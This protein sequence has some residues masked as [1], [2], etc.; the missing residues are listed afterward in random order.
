MLIP[1]KAI[2]EK[3]TEFGIKVTG[4][5]H[6][7]AHECEEGSFYT[8]DLQVPEENLLWVEAIQAKVDEAK[9]K[10]IKHIYQYLVSDQDDKM[11]SFHITNNVQSSSILQFGTHGTH[12]PHIKNISTMSLE[13]KTVD[14]IIR[15][16]RN[17]TTV[18]N[19]WNF[20]IQG[21]ELLALQ[22][23]RESLK[24]VHAIYLE[25]NTEEVYEKCAKVDE[26]DTF[27]A[28]F[29]FSREITRLTSCGWGDALYV[30]RQ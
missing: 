12:Y 6:V 28:E 25:V 26:I 17:N 16:H 30:K 19:F 15:T 4:V 23:A 13:S 22:G 29:G 9:K 8:S 24:E 1:G 2:L 18:Y 3:L 27:L 10:G 7:G 11:L 21:A 5:L 14:Y 20:D